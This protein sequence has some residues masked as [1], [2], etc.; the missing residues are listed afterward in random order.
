MFW[1]ALILDQWQRWPTSWLHPMPQVLPCIAGNLSC[2]APQSL[3]TFADL[4]DVISTYGQLEFLDDSHAECYA[5]RELLL[6][7][8][9]A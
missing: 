1:M 3:M 2:P 4:H 8:S 9:W 5:V 6:L 7:L